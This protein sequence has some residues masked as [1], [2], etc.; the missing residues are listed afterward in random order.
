MFFFSGFPAGGV[1]G[2]AAGGGGGNCV[3]ELFVPWLIWLKKGRQ[4]WLCWFFS[5]WCILIW[6]NMMPQFATDRYQHV[7]GEIQS[8]KFLFE[9]V[10]S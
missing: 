1:G 7:T 4:T 5:L 6:L 2:G 10:P 8:A 3:S 9:K